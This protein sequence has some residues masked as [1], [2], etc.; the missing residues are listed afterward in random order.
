MV[1]RHTE[2]PNQAH[3]VLDHIRPGTQLI[4]PLAN[5]EPTAIIDAIEADASSLVDVRVHQMH[6]LYDRPHMAGAFGTSLQHLSYFLS[7]VT[8]PHF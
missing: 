5:G 8:R 4:V 6:A 7:G 2:A 3:D 1:P